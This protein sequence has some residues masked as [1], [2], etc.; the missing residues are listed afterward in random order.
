MMS[1]RRT[2]TLRRQLPDDGDLR[3]RLQ[4]LSR[5]TCQGT[6]GRNIA[7]R[8]D[9]KEGEKGSHDTS[10][11]AWPLVTLVADDVAPDNQRFH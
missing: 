2:D 6:R 9:R 5:L 3:E 11:S 10:R 4:T 7:E 1:R 8:S